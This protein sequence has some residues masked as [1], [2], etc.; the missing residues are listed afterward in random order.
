MS[1]MN[2]IQKTSEEAKQNIETILRLFIIEGET[3]FFIEYF[4]MIYK[5]IDI[6]CIDC[7]GN[8]FLILSVKQG[9]NYLSKFLLE[10][11]VNTNIQN[12]EGNSAMHY[13]LSMKNFNLADLLKKFGAQEDLINKKGY[14]PWECLGKSIGN[15][16]D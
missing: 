10:R 4:N 6:N 7:D 14:S 3:M 15:I 2:E 5:R 11:G 13:A 9:M 8:T 1:K 12:N 16:D